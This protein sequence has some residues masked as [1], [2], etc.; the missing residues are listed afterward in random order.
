MDERLD[1]SSLYS[2][3]DP[4]LVELLQKMLVFNPEHR[5]SAATLLQ[6]P[7]FDQVR[8]PRIEDLGKELNLSLDFDKT[9]DLSKKVSD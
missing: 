3:S 7:I 6:E 4:K 8:V 5:L 9:Y 1:V 2:K